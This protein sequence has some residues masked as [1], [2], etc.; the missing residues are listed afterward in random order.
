MPPLPPAR[1]KMNQHSK[2]AGG[3]CFSILA[4]VILSSIR[5]RANPIEFPEKSITPK[6]SFVIGFAI[7]LELICICWILRRSRRPRFFILWLVGLHLI[8]YPAF[9]GLLWE[10]VEI[11]P[12][13]AV[14]LGE[15][16]AV[17]IE[18]SLIYLICR[19]VPSIKPKPPA[20][21][22]AKCWLAS[23]IGNA[24]SAAAFPLLLAI[25]ERLSPG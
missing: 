15:G 22:I 24:C 4:A 10:L 21:S 23:L 11:R 9:L 18:G 16:V 5:A 3:R 17:V 12:A 20:P 6:I 13:F 14:A 8:T 1:N 7:L 25:F 19:F 2:F